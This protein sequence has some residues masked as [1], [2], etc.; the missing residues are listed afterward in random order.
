IGEEKLAH[1]V[2]IFCEQGYFTV[3]DTHRILEAGAKYDL[4]GKIH[5]NQFNAIGGIQAGIEHDA[6]SVDH[7][8]VMREEDIRALKNTGTMPVALPSC[9][10]FLGIPYAPA[11]KMIDHGLPVA[12]ATDYNP[13]STPSGNMNLVIS[14]ACIKLKM[15]PEEAINA[16][17]INAAYAMDISDTHG[18]ITKG[19]VASLLLTKPI[20]S[21]GFL[22]YSFGSNHIDKVFING[23][24]IN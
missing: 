9:S 20:P 21:Y 4:K 24:S 18:S 10:L 6:L 1:F 7:L 8:E 13:G 15:T 23:K 5:V 2:D 3:E 17:T 14:L 11:R 22:P 16:A 12:I 19:K